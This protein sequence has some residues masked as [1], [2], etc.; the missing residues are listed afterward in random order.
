VAHV[1]DSVQHDVAGANAC[2]IDSILVTGGV[3]SKDL[4]DYSIGDLP[5][6]ADLQ[7]LFEK[8]GHIPT[9]VVPMFRL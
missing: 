7:R 3:H 1:G 2:G 6:K 9:H 4:S 8:E 5:D